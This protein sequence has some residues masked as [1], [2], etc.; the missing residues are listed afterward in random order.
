MF[1]Q[2]CNQ[3]P[4]D[5]AVA[6]KEWMDCL[7]LHMCKPNSNQRRE[8]TIFMQPLLQRSKRG[9]NL[10]GRRRNKASVAGSATANPVL[11]STNFSRK[12]VLAT[13]AAHQ[14]AVGIAQ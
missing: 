11:R 9:G 6:I 10:L 5:A 7:E 1:H 2:Q 12:L 8:L 3:Q 13:N 4:S 14:D